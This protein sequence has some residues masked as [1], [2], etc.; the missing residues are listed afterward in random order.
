MKIQMSLLVIFVLMASSYAALYSDVRFLVSETGE[1][2][3]TG[4]TNYEPFAGTTQQL[5]S[6]EGNYWVLNITAPVFEEFIYHIQLPK[7]A[8]INYIKANSAVRIEDNDGTLTITSTGSQKPIEVVIQ[9]SIGKA[10]ASA[11]F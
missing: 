9:Y 10:Q 11:I 7:Y 4:N 1:V 8:T 6:K 5:T 2:E 3:I